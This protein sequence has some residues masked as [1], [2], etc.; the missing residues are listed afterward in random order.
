MP[1]L[2]RC[3]REM[4]TCCHLSMSSSDSSAFLHPRQ[5]SRFILPSCAAQHRMQHILCVLV[6]AFFV[7]CMWPAGSS[8]DHTDDEEKRR[9]RWKR[10]E[11]IVGD[12]RRH[13]RRRQQRRSEIVQ[14]RLHIPSLWWK[15]SYNHLPGPVGPEECW[16]HLPRHQLPVQL[17]VRRLFVTE[18]RFF[19]EFVHSSLRA[20]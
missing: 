14:K 3:P 8:F 20:L 4:S 13:T 5:G 18:C 2:E 15:R 11:Q 19:P 16:E 10:E 17:W 9:E 7:Q 12:G 6:V 1:L